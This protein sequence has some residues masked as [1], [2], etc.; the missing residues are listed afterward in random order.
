MYQNTKTTG[1]VGEAKALAKLV[2]LNI[3]VYQQ[4]GDN[5]PADYIILVKNKPLKIQVKTSTVFNGEYTLFSL[6]FNEMHCKNG[7]KHFY[8]KEEVDAFILY[9]YKNN[10]CFLLE[11]N[12]EK[13]NFQ[14]RYSRTK[15]NQKNNINFAS[16]FI[17]TKESLE[18]LI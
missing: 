8:S 3:P 15:N 16:D 17:L 18:K 2:E 14:I 6:C 12:E 9:D 7:W 11:N 13:H 4:F 5:E 10:I 1:N